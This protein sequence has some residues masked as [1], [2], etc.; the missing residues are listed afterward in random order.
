MQQISHEKSPYR[1]RVL[2]FVMSYAENRKTKKEAATYAAT[3]EPYVLE[4]LLL[5]CVSLV[6]LIN[7]T[8]GVN[9]LH[10]TCVEWVRCVRDLE[11]YY[12]VLNTFD[13]DCLLC[14]RARASDED[15]VV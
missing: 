8:C 11:L 12:W 9:E 13:F 6:E 15:L 7:T 10:L 5:L 3:S 2:I 1:V 14:V 4:E